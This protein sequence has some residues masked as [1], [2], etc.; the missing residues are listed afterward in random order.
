MKD[1]LKKAQLTASEIMK[2]LPETMSYHDLNHSRMVVESAK[3]IGTMEG[4]ND[5]DLAMVEIAAW[6]HDTGFQSKY[7]GHEEESCKIARSFLVKEN[8]PEEDI[9][10]VVEAIRAT[11]RDVIPIT[12]LQK[13]LKDADL[14]H[15]ASPSYYA[16]AQSLRNEWSS[17]QNDEYTDVEWMENSLEFLNR[18]QFWTTYGHQVLQPAAD[19]LKKEIKKNLKKTRKVIDQSLQEELGV[20]DEELKKL[21]KKLEKAAGRPERGIETMFRLTSKNHLTLSGMADTK[22]NIMIS[23]NAIIISVLIGSL[24]QKLDS[25]PHLIIPV[26]ILLCVNLVSMI[27]AILS[28]RPN[29]TSGKFTREDI[30]QKKAN[31]LFFGNFHKMQRNDYQW[32]MTRLMEQ[33]NYLY[34]ALI[35]DIYFLGVVLGKKYRFLRIAYNIFMYGI[36]IAVFSFIIANIFLRT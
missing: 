26:A 20:S 30:E 34:S 8:I 7:E 2:E 35:D 27:F 36:V 15:L 3:E 25:N 6:F 17:D 11:A 28:T 16:I 29:V 31:L 14:Y 13:V 4:L 5:H 1:L 19:R 22:A 18:T 21:R 32:G 9:E 10:R 23:V 12:T 24:M 33:S